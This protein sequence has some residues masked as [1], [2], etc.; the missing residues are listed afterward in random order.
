MQDPAAKTMIEIARTQDE[1]VGMHP[2][3][4]IQAYSQALEYAAVILKDTV[5]AKI[6]LEDTSAVRKVIQ[7]CVG[8]MFIANWSDLACDIAMDSVKTITM[9]SGDKKD[10]DIK[11]YAKVEKIPGG[12][13]EDLTVLKGV[14]FNK[15]VTRPKIKRRSKNPRILLLDCHL[16][17]KK[18]ESQT[19]SKILKQEEAYIQKICDEITALKPDLVITEKGVSDLAQHVHNKAGVTA[20]RRLRKSDDLRGARPCGA[21]IVNRTDEIKEEDIRTG[22]GLFEVRKTGDEYFSFIEKD[23][24]PKA[25]TI[26]LHDASKHIRDSDPRQGKSGSEDSQAEFLH[27]RAL[28]QPHPKDL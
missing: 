22:A 3:V 8:T 15:D 11:W 23:K 6:D 5:A 26:L 14:M 7:S 12:R 28:G 13:I 10:I 27:I 20:V 16:E 9:T 1:E 17:Y 19:N 18:G 24:E 25:C 4:V 21:N 2:I